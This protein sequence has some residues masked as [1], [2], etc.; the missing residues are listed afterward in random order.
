[1]PPYSDFYQLCLNVPASNCFSLENS[2]FVRSFLFKKTKTKQQIGIQLFVEMMEFFVKM[3]N[4]FKLLIIFLEGF[5]LE[6]FAYGPE[7]DY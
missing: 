3:I 6:V 2:T 7:G 5:A 4:I 1:M